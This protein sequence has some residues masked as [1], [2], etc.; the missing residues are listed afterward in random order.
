MQI[1]LIR[2]PGNDLF[3][4]KSPPLGITSIAGHLRSTNIA[5]DIS[6]TLLD[7]L[8]RTMSNADVVAAILQ[9]KPTIVGISFL[10]AQA[11]TAYGIAAALRDTPDLLTVAG[12]IHPTVCPGEVA[13]AGFDLVVSG[14]GEAAFEEIVRQALRGDLRVGGEKI[15]RRSLSPAAEIPTPA[16]D[17][18][19]FSRGYN[20]SIGLDDALVIP[21]MA[22]RGCAF[23]CAFCASK[24]IW[25]GKIRWRAPEAVVAEITSLIHNDG[26]RSFHF[27]DDDFLINKRYTIKLLDALEAMPDRIQWTALSTVH[28]ICQNH[29]LLPQ[30]RQLGCCGFDVGVETAD[31]D[32]LKGVNK[33]QKPTDSARALALLKAN[34]FPYVEPLMMYFNEFETVRSVETELEFFHQVGLP[35]L[36]IDLHQYAAPFPGTAFHETSKTSGIRLFHSWSDLRTDRVNYIPHTFLRSIF[37]TPSDHLVHAG[38]AAALDW[39][40]ALDSKNGHE[41]AEAVWRWLRDRDGDYGAVAEMASECAKAMGV[42]DRGEV[43]QITKTVAL[44]S[45]VIARANALARRHSATPRG[46]TA[47][48]DPNRHAPIAPQ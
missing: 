8:P 32:V 36:E 22:A 6:L 34:G 39:S 18:L 27:Y 40:K 37:P 33:L 2:P 41:V 26:I 12:G 7:F 14:E 45:I 30:L 38:I 48:A 15:R 11:E 46:A 16:W 43:D 29:E 19:D 1:V 20:E 10:T 9:H 4:W 44:V 13:S 21:I 5:D 23:D 25:K 31:S 17:L 35:D 42:R 47:I 28:S 24:S 3:R